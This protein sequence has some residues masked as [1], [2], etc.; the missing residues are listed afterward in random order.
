M[1]TAF[2]SIHLTRNLVCRSSKDLRQNSLFRL[3]EQ[4][5]SRG[6]ASSSIAMSVTTLSSIT[7]DL[8]SSSLDNLQKRIQQFVENYGQMCRLSLAVAGGGGHFLSTLA[9]TP[10][11]SKILLKGSILYDRESYRRFVRRTLPGESFRYASVESSEYAS[12]AALQQALSLAAAADPRY[13]HHPTSNLAN[14][15]GIGAASA[16]SSNDGTQKRSR[17]YVTVTTS[18][19][20][21]ITF[22]A[23]LAKTGTDADRTRME[24]DVFVAHCILA[25][26]ECALD[27]RRK[28][29]SLTTNGNGPLMIDE[30]A[31]TKRGDEI[32]ITASLQQPT[33]TPDVLSKAAELILDGKQESVMLLAKKDA[34]KAD[35]VGG[36]SDFQ[37]IE[38]TVLPPLSVVFPGSFF[39]PHKGHIQLAKAALKKVD[40]EIVWFELSL[41]NADKPP[42]QI[43]DVVERLTAFLRLREE[44]PVHWGILLTN[45]PLFKQKVDLL[46]PLQVSRSYNDEKE[47]VLPSLNFVIGTDTLVRILNPKYYDNSRDNMFAAL[48]SMP[49]HFVVG[50]RVEQKKGVGGDTEHPVFV[51][52]QAD[53]DQLP[54]D[55][56]DNFSLLDDFR[57]DI[58]S[59]EI[60]RQTSK[61]HLTALDTHADPS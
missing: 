27:M 26:L 58:S 29:A 23:R 4:L 56:K 12:D 52:G 49:C 14:A 34:N 57:V 35:N 31:T 47:E 61:E 51:S 36:S 7:E 53:V 5:F 59:T 13:G 21:K 10:G 1:N 8:E 32:G 48:R 50:G 16:L 2:A 19:S 42:L 43:D 55:L 33:T 30:R 25:T 22:H 17:A 39:P 44:M 15:V 41:T 24:E 3:K 9:S 45:A 40:C 20:Y 11:A 46:H 37:I 6:A 38:R 60:R 18:D 28:F 54:D